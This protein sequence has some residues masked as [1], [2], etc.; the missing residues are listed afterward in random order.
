MNDSFYNQ[1]EQENHDQP[2]GNS[3]RTLSESKLRS[4]NPPTL[5]QIEAF[6]QLDHMTKT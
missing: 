6:P 4:F 1:F 2:D 3:P 5:D